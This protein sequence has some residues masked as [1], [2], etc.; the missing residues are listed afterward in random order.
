MILFLPPRTRKLID[1]YFHLKIGRFDISCPYYQNITKK[2]KKPVFAGKGLPEEI[3]KETIELFHK[4]GKNLE[5]FDEFSLRYYMVMLGLGIDCSG[6]VAR[7]L[8]SFLQEKGLGGIKNNTKPKNNSLI[9]FLRHFVRIYSNLSADVLT[10]KTNCV[11]VKNLNAVVPGD[12]LR[13]GRKHIAIITEVEK[14]NSVVKRITYCHS[15]CD[16]FEQ[17]GVRKGD[18]LIVKPKKPLE[19]QKWDEFY[20][21]RNWMF[22]DFMSADKSDRGI[23]RLRCLYK[24]T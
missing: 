22:E 5:K 9:E 3:E 6:F 23:R 7:V 15:T 21:G 18:I 24:Q 11:E 16:Y 13:V 4:S 14:V 2:I 20:R 8:D 12:L 10:N 1:R 19:N 17:Y